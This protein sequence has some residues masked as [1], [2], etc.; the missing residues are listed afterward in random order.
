MSDL[1][2]TLITPVL[3]LAGGVM[4][5][6]AGRLIEHFVLTPAN[7]LLKVRGEIADALIYYADLY[8]NPTVENA[9]ERQECGDRLRQLSSKLY[10]RLYVVHCYWFF[11]FLN[12]L[13]RFNEV[14]DAGTHLIG[15]SNKVKGGR[16]DKI[17]EILDKRDKVE[18]NLRIVTGS[19]DSDPNS[20]AQ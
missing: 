14:S 5:L 12:I 18:R 8:S 9:P 7:E 3:T 11:T 20:A 16:Q 1:T 2:Q 10:A 19:S 15:M 17:Q 13:P 6:V 4:L